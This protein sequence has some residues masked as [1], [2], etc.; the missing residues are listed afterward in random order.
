MYKLSVTREVCSPVV[1]G[2]AKD[3]EVVGVAHAVHKAHR[4]PLRHQ[5]G[6]SPDNLP[7]HLR[8]LVCL[9]CMVTDAFTSL[10]LK[11]AGLCC[12]VWLCYN[13]RGAND[14]ACGK[15]NWIWQCRK[16]LGMMS[17]L[18]SHQCLCWGNLAR[19][20]EPK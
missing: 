14:S 3:A 8:M 20:L 13:A 15:N 17:S 4:L 19:V 12:L 2:L 18:R 16:I 6:C 9:I 5:R 11:T 10:A 1:Y 7:Q